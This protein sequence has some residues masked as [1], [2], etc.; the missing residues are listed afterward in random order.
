MLGSDGLVALAGARAFASTA[1]AER[2][3]SKPAE[4]AAAKRARD[5]AEIDE[6][7]GARQ[8]AA[9]AWRELGGLRW[10][11]ADDPRGAEQAFYFASTLGGDDGLRR[12]A[13]DLCEFAGVPDGMRLLHARAD[14]LA[15]QGA[16]RDRAAVFIEIANRAAAVGMNDE[17]LVAAAQ[18]IEIDPSRADA[19]ALVERSAGAPGGLATLDRT[20]DLLADAALGRYGRRAAHYRGA[21]QLERR[22]AAALALRHAIACFEAV[23]TEGTAYVLLARLAERVGD[24]SEAVRAI[25]RVAQSGVPAVR[26][27]WLKRAADLAGTSSDGQETRFDVL[28]RALHVRP[29]APVVERIVHVARQLA[30]AGGDED[31]IRMRLSRALR[32]VLPRLEG[33]DGARTAI[34]LAR[35]ALSGFADAGLATVALERAMAVDGDVDEYLTLGTHLD[36][37]VAQG[38]ALTRFLDLVGAEVERPY[39]SRGP[40]G[41]R[42]PRA[43]AATAGDARRAATLRVQ[44]ARRAPEDDALVHA[45]DVAVREIGDE[46]LLR[47]LDDALPAARRI[48]ALLHLAAQH[49]REGRDAEAV[50]ALERA[51]ESGKLGA[52]ERDR[53]VLRVRHLLGVTGRSTDVEALLRREVA[54][55]EAAQGQ[56]TKLARDLS[57][58]LAARGDWEGALEVL[59]ELTQKVTPDRALLVEV[60]RLARR[61]GDRARQAEV[62]RRLADMAE[63]PASRLAALR[64][65]LPVAR[66]LGD[67]GGFVAACEAVLRIDP[68]DRAA[69]EGLEQDASERSDHEGLAGLLARRITAAPSG[70]ARRA[71][72]LR[73]AAVLEQRLGRLD[74]ACVELETLLSEVP[75]DRSAYRFLADVRERL[76]TPLSA[77]ALWRRLGEL[78]TSNDEKG[79]YGLR[80]ASSYLA[81]GDL[82]A[83]REAMDQVASVAPREALIELRVELARRDGDARALSEALEQL[84]AISTASEERLGEIL[85]EASRAASA[86]GDEATALERARRAAKLAP[87][88]ADAVLEARRLEYLARGTGTPRQAQAAAQELG[89]IA[90]GLDEE[91]LELLAFLLA[92]E[93][94]VIQGGGAGM[95]ELSRRHAEIGPRPLIALGMAERLSMR[96]SFGAALPLFERALAGDLRGLRG[97]GRVALAAAEAAV[98]AGELDAAARFLEE[99]AV[100]PETRPLATRRQLELTALRGEPVAAEHALAELAERTT[101]LDRARALA[102]LARVMVSVPDHGRADEVRDILDRAR[103]LAGPDRA[104]AEQIAEELAR[105]DAPKS[106]RELPP[107]PGTPVTPLPDAPQPPSSEGPPSSD[108]RRID[109]VQTDDSAPMPPPSVPPPEPDPEDLDDD[110]DGPPARIWQSPSPSRPPPPISSPT[111]TPTPTPTVPSAMQVAGAM[112]E[113]PRSTSTS[114]PATWRGSPSS[115]PHSMPATSA[116]PVPASAPPS[117]TPFARSGPAAI[118]AEAVTSSGPLGPDSLP[119]GV[120][121]FSAVERELIDQLRGGSVDAGDRLVGIWGEHAPDRAHDLLAVRKQQV[122]LRPGDR[123]T[124][125]R[126]RLAA[127]ADGNLAYERALAHVLS[128]FAADASPVSPRVDNQREATPELVSSLLFRKGERAVNEALALA[129]ETG[130]FRR[131]ANHYRLTGLERVQLGAATAVG[132]AYTGV[133]RLL[134]AV[135]TPLFHPRGPGAPARRSRCSGRRR[136]SSPATC[137]STPASSTT[138]SAPRSRPPCPSMRWW[139]RGPRRRCARC[140]PPCWLPSARS[141]PPRRGRTAVIP[142]R[143]PSWS[144]IS[145]SWYRRAPRAAWPRSAPTPP[146]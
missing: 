142:S 65:L 84:A 118:S 44:A 13:V 74:E 88:N 75:G 83:A 134:G 59:A 55:P 108:G 5:P 140:S 16:A 7:H 51:I 102:Q 112:W 72:R 49:E 61:T 53:A 48:E 8:R 1:L 93:L 73:R 146:G 43:A 29:D 144:A 70:D 119:S 33:P 105:L 124:L 123:A 47:S 80:A 17:A 2:P 67:R 133:A 66:E 42:L 4:A 82:A 58:Q 116:G 57:A 106:R 143:W 28:L 98:N 121:V 90:D 138:S 40:A 101:G 30:A 104:L 36:A 39:A 31:M 10:D 76:G 27:G 9:T 46:A 37:L 69:L 32:A 62:L 34:A 96:R 15:A 77:A 132:E 92:E 63:D 89:A 117:S 139:R 64:E 137:A 25:E 50:A 11:L 41:R 95:R 126:A 100:A 122:A 120:K 135:R 125:E 127:L 111:P 141:T 114:G 14:A 136:S 12:Y 113:A 20:Y 38:E 19:V 60:H 18:A 87:L 107:L 54:R 94:D 35:A 86:I 3:D 78:S 130:M 71:L 52:E 99:A 21:R 128:C 6:R 109:V 103:A 145:G 115:H 26:S 22:G 85:L 81:G 56:R 91:R 24:A 131:D 45:A 68:G 129:W 97:R 23:P 79:E 110:D